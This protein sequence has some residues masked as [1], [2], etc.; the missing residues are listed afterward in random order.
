[1]SV[2][3]STSFVFWPG[4]TDNAP[5]R[6][7]R[8]VHKAV[9]AV[10]A[11]AA[12]V[13]ATVGVESAAL[14][15]SGIS[16]LVSQ[17]AAFSVLGH[18]CGG[19]QEQS[20]ATG[21]DA[22]SGFPTGD[23]YIST[24][25]GG[26]GRLGG[27]HVT[28]YSAWVEA[29]WDFRGAQLSNMVLS[30]AP[31]VDPTFSAFDQFGNEVYNQSN[32]A[33]LLLA[34]GFVPEP[35][36]TGISPTSGPAAGGTTVTIGGDGFT[37]ATAV[38]FG[39][40]PA[41]S[42]TVNSDTSITAVSPLESGGTVDVTVTTAGGTS[43]SSPEDQFTFVAAPVVSGI[44]PDSGPVSGGTTVTIT[45]ANFT[46]ASSVTFGDSL[47]GFSVID[48]TSITAVSPGVE[49][50]DDVQV[51]V[52]SIGG[53]SAT[54]PADRF[55]YVAPTC[56]N[57]VIDPGEQCD[58]GNTFNGDGCSAQ[59]TIESCYTCVGQ[60]SSCS[61]SPVGTACDD[62]NACTVGET[63]DGAGVCGGFTS[64]RVNSTCNICGQMCTQP[65]PG[66]CKCG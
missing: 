30:G 26:S 47:A 5:G 22:T 4:E 13:L 20:F 2:Q 53:T 17:G 19:I 9:V 52:A 41:T 65:A 50:P 8:M 61:P 51:R 39:S 58:D 32:R 33:Y 48:D 46:E 23:V 11:L 16:L 42:L 10:I 57:G 28:T 49:G 1:M 6:G 63:C 25:C 12:L 7:G 29:T 66:V 43:A 21:F 56:G 14:G 60:P 36:V 64:C 31:A 24:R 54:V 55:M 3:S 27:G 44:S 37:G 59:C 40:D 34:P 45:G 38:S 35:R 62:G 15:Q 18:S